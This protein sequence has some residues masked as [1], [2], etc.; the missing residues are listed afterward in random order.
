MSDPELVVV[1]EQDAGLEF[2]VNFGVFAGRD[3]TRAEVE[4]LAR[5]LLPDVDPVEIV[6]EQRYEFGPD[7]EAT[8]YVVRVE[9]P[10]RNDAIRDSLRETIAA[11]AREC[12]AERRFISI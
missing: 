7:R 2:V 9:T 3:A 5:A 4:R 1:Q 10:P 11:W 12:I 8:V 6:C